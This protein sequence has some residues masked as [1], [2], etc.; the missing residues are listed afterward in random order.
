MIPDVNALDKPEFVDA[1]RSVL[2]DD[3][4][5]LKIGYY[6]VNNDAGVDEVPTWRD[7]WDDPQ[8]AAAADS[9]G[10]DAGEGRAVAHARHRA[11]RGARGRLPR[12]GR[13][14]PACAAV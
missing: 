12:L 14:A 8:A 2:A 13:R 6:G 3:I 10:R 5:E 4:K 11:A 7:Q 1:E 9:R